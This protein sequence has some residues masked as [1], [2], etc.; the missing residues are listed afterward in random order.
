P[1]A[2]GGADE[3][4]R[5]PRAA[6]GGGASRPRGDQL[7]AASPRSVLLAD[8]GAARGDPRRG[9]EH[10]EPRRGGEPRRAAASLPPPP[11]AD[12]HSA[13]ES[14]SRSVEHHAVP[15]PWVS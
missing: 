13:G 1:P 12:G 9:A 10:Q 3:R 4:E 8:G 6:S 2:R 15:E 14:S 5:A 7:R 11:G